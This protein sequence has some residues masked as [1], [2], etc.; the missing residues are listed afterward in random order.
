M[1]YTKFRTTENRPENVL[2]TYTSRICWEHRYY[3]VQLVSTLQVLF[4]EALSSNPRQDW[5]CLSFSQCVAE[6]GGM[7]W[8]A[9]PS[10]SLTAI[11]LSETVQPTCKW[12]DEFLGADGSCFG[13]LG[14]V[15]GITDPKLQGWY[16][17]IRLY[18]VLTQK[19]TIWIC[20]YVK[21]KREAIPV[22]CRGGL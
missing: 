7:S 13:I 8:H 17:P 4:L 6:T 11:P 9:V 5:S 22:T 2:S 21:V 14:Y 16:K 19:T 1:F 15:R 10:L 20:T 18:G 3:V 12:R